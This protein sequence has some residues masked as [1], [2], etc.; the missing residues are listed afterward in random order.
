MA[1]EQWVW[2]G[3]L[4]ALPAGCVAWG[5][6]PSPLVFSFLTCMA[7]ALGGGGSIRGDVDGKKHDLLQT[8]S[9]CAHWCVQ[10]PAVT[11]LCCQELHL[12]EWRAGLLPWRTE[13]VL[14]WPPG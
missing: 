4:P 7:G 6:P 11:L 13:G 2:T 3:G 14:E 8:K 12:G 9:A 5:N 10:E 1:E